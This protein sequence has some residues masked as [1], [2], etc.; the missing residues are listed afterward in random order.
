MSE[1]GNLPSPANVLAYI[2]RELIE[3]KANMAALEA[4]V[5]AQRQA[6][7]TLFVALPVSKRPDALALLRSQQQG[8]QAEGEAGA[9]SIL[10]A[11][12]D[13]MESM[14]GEGMDGTLQQAT[15]TVSLNA[16]LLQNAPP[17]KEEAMRSW[18]GFATEGEIAQEMLALPPEKLD[19]L[20]R[21]NTPAKPA[22]RGGA[23]KGKKK[24]KKGD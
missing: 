20:L 5:E 16:A 21:L 15:A 3:I 6:I 11:L 23:S 17:G 4:T 24:P 9:A 14:I 12:V 22:R 19:A 2:L 1:D 7:D 18:L 8:L 10:G 13:H